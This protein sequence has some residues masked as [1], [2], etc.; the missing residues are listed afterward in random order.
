VISIKVDTAAVL[1]MLG[2]A[3]RQM[4]FAI[5]KGLN[6]AAQHVQPPEINEM[7][8]AFDRPTSYT[9]NSLKLTPSK[10]TNLSASVW[11][12]NP[13][14]LG[15]HNHYLEPQ[16]FGGKRALKPWEH[17]MGKR[18]IM[19]AKGTKLDAHGNLGRGMITK[20]RS[21]YGSQS[22]AGFDSATKAKS[23]RDPYFM[24]TKR[25]GNLMAGIYERVQGSETAGRVARYAIA[26]SLAKKQGKL[27]DLNKRTRALYPRGIKPV[28]IF[29]DKQPSYSKRFDFFGVAKRTI[30][31]VLMLNMRA[32]VE[33]A[34]RT[35]RAY[36]QRLF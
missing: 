26:R 28:V 8:R 14:T 19:P 13:P 12:K 21:M 15:S 32:A 33:D 3:S 29:T 23:K 31:R 16:V 17:S 7:K 5:S 35:A 27:G 6:M 1:R 4:P 10:K 24:V 22:V 25:K 11:F 2:N 36:Q 9:L 18:Y 34:L 20:L 30:D